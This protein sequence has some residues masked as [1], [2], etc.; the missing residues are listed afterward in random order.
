MNGDNIGVCLILIYLGTLVIKKF[1]P[2]NKILPFIDSHYAHI[3]CYLAF[4]VYLY[5]YNIDYVTRG[6]YGFI[7]RDMMFMIVSSVYT[8]G[9][10]IDAHSSLFERCAIILGIMTL[11]FAGMS[12]AKFI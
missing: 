1:Y 8:I 5:L 9:A 10:Y 11:T 7:R 12:Y 4:I 3:L 6:R 2:D